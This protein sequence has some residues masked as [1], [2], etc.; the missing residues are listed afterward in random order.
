VTKPVK[1]FK[2]E[3]VKVETSDTL[4]MI[5]ITWT[6]ALKRPTFRRSSGISQSKFWKH[7][8]LSLDAGFPWISGGR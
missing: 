4:A 8:E 3:K 7:I 2:A 6:M 5:P 1:A